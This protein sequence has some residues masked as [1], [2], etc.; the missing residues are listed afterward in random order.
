[1]KFQRGFSYVI[2]VL[3]GLLATV[4]AFIEIR[5]A[6][7]GDF[8]LMQNP[9][10]SVVGYVC[11]AIFYVA[12]LA[13]VIW[14]FINKANKKRTTLNLLILSGLLVL[15]SVTLFFFYM[16]AIALVVLVVNALVAT[17][18]IVRILSF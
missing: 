7:A 12:M 8:T 9:S 17:I 15:S 14:I 1:M 6:V 2:L 10:N 18:A 13:N 11:R 5:S 4:F 3:A 16:F